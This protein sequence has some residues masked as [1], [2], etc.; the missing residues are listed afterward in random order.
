MMTLSGDRAGA[1]GRWCPPSYGLGPGAF[2]SAPAVEAEVIYVAGGL[3][4]NPFALAR[5]L[6]LF[7]HEPASS[8]Q[9]VFNGDFH[10]FDR[11][12]AVF[13][14]IERDTAPFLRLRGN[15]ETE[16][17]SAGDDAGCG[18]GYP[19]SVSDG[20]VARSNAILAE[21]KRTARHLG[22]DQRLGALPP[23]ARARCDALQ[24][25]I[26]HGD[27]RSLAGWDLAADRIDDSWKAGLDQ[28]LQAL[29]VGL[30]ASSHTCLAVASTG[31]SDRSSH[32]V[33]N[34]GSA[35][36][37]NFQGDAAG[38]FTRIACERWASACAESPLYR[39]NIQGVDVAAVPLR[40]DQRAWQ[41]AFLEQWPEGSAAYRS[42]WTRIVNGPA[43]CP[44]QAARGHFRLCD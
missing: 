6:E 44:G 29:G 11:S 9:L 22:C 2:A 10:W 42:Y 41:S 36:M 7:E 3:Y 23:V 24:I 17:A 1:P 15:V 12:A 34:N 37:A 8:K 21:L 39:A 35:G 27:D 14:S 16:I 18:C 4:G 5:L 13:A 26:T 30:I 28:R 19:D 38:L 32:A 40:F 25:A 43:H 31:L 33:I 20:D